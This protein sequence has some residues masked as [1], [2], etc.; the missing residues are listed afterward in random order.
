MLNLKYLSLVL[1]IVF[2]L[3]LFLFY[4]IKSFFHKQILKLPPPYY[5]K[6][7]NIKTINKLKILA[8]I[9]EQGILDSL[10]IFFKKSGYYFVGTPNPIL[11]LNNLKQEHFD[12]SIF[13][14]TT[15]LQYERNIIEEIRDI[16][17]DL[18]I[19]LLTNNNQI[20]LSYDFIKKLA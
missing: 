3:A 19:L 2:F 16:D 9:D 15:S 12:I 17:N 5:Q 1:I 20:T 10:N 13:D 11:A 8:V 6:M 18:Y 14:Y 4:I 7:D